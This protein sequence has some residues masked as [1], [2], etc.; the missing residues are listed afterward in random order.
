MDIK[1]KDRVLKFETWLKQFCKTPYEL[2][3]FENWKKEIIEEEKLSLLK[4]M[5]NDNRTWQEPIEVIQ[6]RII[7]ITGKRVNV[8]FTKENTLESKPN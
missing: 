6:E 7:D 2:E 5:F 1:E 8:V 3:C 4:E